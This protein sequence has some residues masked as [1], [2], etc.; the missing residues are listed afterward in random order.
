MRRSLKN[1]STASV[2]STGVT[3][4]LAKTRVWDELDSAALKWKKR[5]SLQAKERD[6]KYGD[7]ALRLGASQ[8]VESIWDVEWEEASNFKRSDGGRSSG[9]YFVQLP[10]DR[11]VVVKPDDEVVADYC[12]FVLALY[13]DVHHPD[14][15]VVRL[16]SAEGKRI[17]G[18]LTRL[19]AA[20]PRKQRAKPPIATTL[21]AVPSVLVMN[22]VRGRSLKGVALAGYMDRTEADKFCET[23]LGPPGALSDAGRE[24]LREIGR[25]MAFD[26]FIFN[27]D[28]LPCVFD[29]GGNTENIMLSDGGEVIAI[30]SMISC[31]DATASAEARA[32]FDRFLARVAALVAA[33]VEK[34]DEPHPAFA[35]VR[36]L[37]LK[38]RGDEA[39]EA[40][41]PPLHRDIG[42][43][44][45][46]EL[47][48][49]FI[50]S[51]AKFDAL[52]RRSLAALPAAVMRFLGV[53][54][55]AGAERVRA[56]FLGEV[57]DV[58]TKRGES[59]A[60]PARHSSRDEPL[61]I[62]R[63]GERELTIRHVGSDGARA[64]FE[65]SKPRV[66]ARACPG[67]EGH[68]PNSAQLYEE[69]L[70]I[71]GLPL[72][73]PKPWKLPGRVHADQF[74]A[75]GHDHLSVSQKKGS[76]GSVYTTSSRR[77]SMSR[78]DSG[79]GGGG[80]DASGV[81][82][83]VEHTY[84]RGAPWWCCG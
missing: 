10:G 52:P 70:G 31:F 43:D 60:P 4:V 22:L 58:F 75:D 48:A 72:P 3:E 33:C 54:E 82:V 8:P 7:A 64:D 39:D 41:C 38:G 23:M 63:S 40:F 29:N 77:E 14:M 55:G 81:E 27:Y 61:E 69:V 80:V 21:A 45:V 16:D 34:P 5:G 65:C 17:T 57:L 25:M 30:D 67:E 35:A 20:K 68:C 18:A 24:R 59:V 12:G 1:R 2:E 11:V 9:V 26:I 71:L 83:E 56:D 51:F 74:E 37:L 50:E 62:V 73:D 78:R 53:D 66:S 28:R 19:D 44:G 84:Q 15:R 42:D 6:A 47:Q 49:G 36:T 32:Q 76:R 13:F 79:G 46:R